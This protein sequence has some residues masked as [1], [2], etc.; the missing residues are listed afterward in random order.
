MGSGL[1]VLCFCLCKARQT[2]SAIMFLFQVTLPQDR[3]QRKTTLPHRRDVGV[4][5]HLHLT[6]SWLQPSEVWHQHL[7]FDRHI[8]CQAFLPFS[9]GAIEAS[10][11]RVFL[12]NPLCCP[13]QERNW[14]ALFAAPPL[15]DLREV[16]QL[17][18][19]SLW[20]FATRI[21]DMVEHIRQ[22]DDEAQ[23]SNTRAL[24]RRC[25]WLV[26]V[27]S[28]QRCFA[29]WGIGVFPGKK[30]DPRT[31][32][33]PLLSKCTYRISLMKA[34]LIVGRALEFDLVMKNTSAA[35]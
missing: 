24:S 3:E 4:F 7:G 27:P 16:K 2:W 17:Q 5:Y 35:P 32:R 21:L 22:D 6:P 18:A 28:L 8:I 31:L 19:L 23:K 25:V 30:P 9:E 12:P 34:P 10:V 15:R 26:C 20:T 1:F 33:T 14:L 13:G 11:P 29:S